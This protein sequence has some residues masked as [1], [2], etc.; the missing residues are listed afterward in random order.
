[1]EAVEH[2]FPKEACGVRPLLSPNASPPSRRDQMGV[3]WKDLHDML[4]KWLG[5]LGDGLIRDQM[6]GSWHD[7]GLESNDICQDPS[8]Q[9]NWYYLGSNKSNKHRIRSMYFE[10]QRWRSRNGRP[11]TSPAN[12]SA[13]HCHQV[14]RS[15]STQVKRSHTHPSS[16]LTSS[17]AGHPDYR[18]RRPTT[19][20][21]RLLART[22]VHV[23]QSNTPLGIRACDL[24]SRIV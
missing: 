21:I 11:R 23:P 20:G 7:F 8:R 24:E 22:S 16:V 15:S 9:E 6:I 14:R 12:D 5:A 18:H 2:E 13:L 17:R 19:A 3:E 1:M 4:L 10:L